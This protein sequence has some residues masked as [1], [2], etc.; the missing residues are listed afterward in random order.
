MLQNKA[1][2]ATLSISAWTARKQDKKVSAEV[3]TAHG[4]HDAGRYNKMLV[5]KALLDPVSKLTG[6]I[7]E[8]HYAMT[9]PWAD[10]G[11]RLLP[12]K[13]FMD[14]SSAVRSFRDQFTKLVKDLQA[15]YP[16]EVQ[17]ARTRLGSMYDPDDYPDP[18]DLFGKF[19][20]ALD[21]T[22]VP[23]AADFRVDVGKEAQDELRESVTQGVAARQAG[24]VKATYARIHEVVSKIEERLSLDNAIFKDSLIDNANELCVVL[25]AL[26]ITNDPVITA[27]AKRIRTELVMPPSLLRQNPVARQRV[28]LA[29]RDILGQLPCHG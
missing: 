22:P 15:A 20:I 18:S 8:Y 24:A 10:S 12:S 13:L 29:A 4:A 11:A 25:D 2:L 14:Y 6:K 23:D 3:E 5:N 27:L 1:M 7:R 26:N 17:A 16:A 21:F 28:A 19:G 9:L